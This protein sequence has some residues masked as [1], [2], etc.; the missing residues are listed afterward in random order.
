[1]AGTQPPPTTYQSSESKCEYLIEFDG[2]NETAHLG[3][4]LRRGLRSRFPKVFVVAHEG[5]IRIKANRRKA[6]YMRGTGNKAYSSSCNAHDLPRSVLKER[7]N[8]IKTLWRGFEPLKS[9]PCEVSY[10]NA[11]FHSSCSRDGC[12]EEHFRWTPLSCITLSPTPTTTHGISGGEYPSRNNA[13]SYCGLI[14]QANKAGE[15]THWVKLSF[16]Q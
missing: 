10:Q 9:R 6:P 7:S 12:S 11:R 3:W 4:R 1:M 14:K 13:T 2:G 16:V 15:I 5:E 8:T